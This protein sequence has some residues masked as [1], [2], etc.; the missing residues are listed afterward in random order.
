MSEELID[1]PQR[2]AIRTLLDNDLFV[3]AG[4]GT[5]KT[6]ELTRRVVALIASG[7]ATTAEM[8]VITFTEAAAAELRERVR[9]ALEN[10]SL[11]NDSFVVDRCRRALDGLD[12]AA[13]ETIHAFA[14]RLLQQ[15]A[16]EAGLP[17]VFRVV[18]RTESGLTWRRR[19]HAFVSSTLTARHELDPE[20]DHLLRTAIALGV[21]VRQ[22]ASLARVMHQAWD[23]VSRV[24]CDALPAKLDVSG[25][26]AHLDSALALRG[27]CT[28]DADR[29][30]RFIDNDMCRWKARLVGAETFYSQIEV[31]LKNP[32]LT[33]KRGVKGNWSGDIE[34]VRESL[35]SAKA[36]R[37][38]LLDGPRQSV[39][40]GLCNLL[41]EFT[42]AGV[43]ERVSNGDLEF[44]DLLVLSRN[45]LRDSESVRTAVCARYKHLLVDEFQDTD[46]LQAEI[47]SMITSSE[48]ARRFTVGDP[49][50]SIY[51]FRG[52]DVAQYE[53]VKSTSAGV[54]DL[55]TN[56]RTAPAVLEWIEAVTNKLPGVASSVSRPNLTA[57]RDSTGSVRVIGSASETLTAAQVREVEAAEVVEQIRTTIEG[58]WGVRGR[59]GARAA[60]YADVAILIP[61]RTALP[62][63][64]RALNA[65]SIPFRIE[66]R[67]L[68]WAT[69][70]LRDVVATLG[71]IDDPD[72]PVSLVASLRS[73][74]FGCGD[75]DLLSWVQGGGS[76]DYRQDIPETL[77]T[78]PVANA[79]SWLRERHARRWTEQVATLVD[80]LIRERKLFQLAYAQPRQ[81]ES[82]HRLRFLSDQVAQWTE[83]GGS[84]LSNFVTWARNQA[85]YGADAREVIVAEPDD[86]AVRVMTIHAAKGL[87]FPVVAVTGI[88]SNPP[89]KS[90][91]RALWADDHFEVRIGNKTTGWETRG[92]AEADAVDEQGQAEESDR[93]LYVAL[94]RARDHLLVSVHHAVRSNKSIAAR[95]LPALEGISPPT[96]YDTMLPLVPASSPALSQIGFDIAERAAQRSNVVASAARALS[97][98]ATGINRFIEG[99]P[100]VPAVVGDVEVSRGERMAFG[101]VVH[102]VLETV[103]LPHAAT[104]D[105]LIAHAT[106]LEPLAAER[107]VEI[108]RSVQLALDSR[109]LAEALT[110]GRY[111]RELGGSIA[112][113]DLILEGLIDLCYETPAG[114]VI[115]DYKTDEVANAGDVVSLA[116]HYKWQLLTYRRLLSANL[117]MPVVDVMLLLINPANEKAVEVSLTDIDAKDGELDAE[118]AIF[119][120]R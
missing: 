27:S 108:K 36:A 52:A 4:A 97:V 114:L 59:D 31:L 33:S 28:D 83:A 116:N 10:E 40:T 86:D 20:L 16:S 26:V 104:V 87:E 35:G 65:A 96:G 110:S 19:W 91:A 72:D 85:E 14:R 64:E 3:E 37:D 70:E 60:K 43:R 81:R 117:E 58:G 111:W 46:P 77:A 22:L 53:L 44:H 103:D 98:S 51:R 63:T 21:N 56:F 49:R 109:P 92:F 120:Q 23:R 79:F 7:R 69:Q 75:D 100:Q 17:P 30:A 80:E 90:S 42:L 76:W 38:A 118:L 18:D 94:T 115:V 71:A 11:T 101:R 25:V 107:T 119:Q 1:R 13:I 48:Q 57:H 88:N 2:D 67:S 55:S 29:M 105:D 102:W 54:R 112:H 106:Q 66:S 84:T 34:T 74:V 45:V 41:A 9:E 39:I 95:L 8:A 32:R 6:T 93:L 47:V 61:G 24:A 68:I 12:D 89:N 73:I 15:N 78:H 82:W 113:G 50:Q 5:G 62:A 99:E